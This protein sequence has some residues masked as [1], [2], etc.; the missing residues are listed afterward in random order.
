M[1]ECQF[2][3]YK[4]QHPDIYDFINKQRPN[5]YQSHKHSVTENQILQSVVDETLFGMVEVD[6]EVPDQ[7]PSYFRHESMTPF[8][9]FSEMCPLFCNT[10]VPYEMI[11]K[12]MQTH[13]QT[14]KLST[15][16]RK[17]LVAGMKGRQMLIATP[18]QPRI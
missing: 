13:V 12:H 2:K 6:I 8:E 17:L 4:K 5:F 18:Y 1:W 3:Q 7:W 9:Y 15:G 14:H 10:E 16:P 11:G